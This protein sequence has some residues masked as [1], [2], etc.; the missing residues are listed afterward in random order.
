MLKEL[1]RKHHPQSCLP[2]NWRGIGCIHLWVHKVFTALINHL[3]FMQCNLPSVVLQ[4]TCHAFG[5]ALVEYW[6]AK[7]EKLS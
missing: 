7:V 2:S 3:W 4:E 1:Q 5:L 6:E